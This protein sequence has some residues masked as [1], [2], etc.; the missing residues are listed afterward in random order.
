MADTIKFAGSKALGDDYDTTAE[1][2]NDLPSDITATSGHW[3][4]KFKKGFN[5]DGFTIPAFIITDDD[6]QI[7]FEA[8]D[9][10][11]VD[12]TGSGAGFESAIGNAGGLIETQTAQQN[13]THFN[14]IGLKII[15]TAGFTGQ[16]ALDLDDVTNKLIKDCY[17]SNRSVSG[18]GWGFNTPN[19]AVCITT[20]ENCIIADCTGSG[21]NHGNAGGSS[22]ITMNRVTSV[23]NGDDG[24]DD[25]GFGPAS[26]IESYRNLLSFGN[27]DND[28]NS[29]LSDSNVNYFAGGDG[30]QSEAPINFTATSA[31]FVD[32]ANGD[33]SLASNSSLKGAGEN[34]EDIGATLPANAGPP[35]LPTIV[36]DVKDVELESQSVLISIVSSLNGST[37]Q[38]QLNVTS[39]N[40]LRDAF[41]KN[42]QSQN[43][44][45]IS[46]LLVVTSAELADIY[47]QKNKAQVE[48]VNNFVKNDYHISNIVSSN[49]IVNNVTLNNKQVQ[50]ESSFV[51]TF[52][53]SDYYEKEFQ[54][55][56]AQI[57]LTSVVRSELKDIQLQNSNAQG[58]IVITTQASLSD[59]NFQKENYL[60]NVIVNNSTKESQFNFSYG[61]SFLEITS[62]ALL[63]DISLQNDNA[64]LSN[65]INSNLNDN[66]FH[67]ENIKLN[68]LINSTLQDISS[69]QIKSLVFY[70][71]V[72]GIG[73]G[74]VNISVLGQSVISIDSVTDFNLNIK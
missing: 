72:E 30:T 69:Q 73:V 16:S 36:C 3:R 58:N 20:F 40:S 35:P 62:D 14:I 50:L 18:S 34:G 52:I 38:S 55:S 46:K 57:F 11:E 39:L 54:D 26:F 5:F 15:A 67:I 59:I 4:V 68:S 17:I 65:N 70:N 19:A 66:T 27:T 31:D 45:A 47:Y 1:I 63:M 22:R 13:D 2:L 33:Y 21:T 37:L 12:G 49:A 71:L 29:R 32:Y 74:K 61:E 8:A 44:K 28:F 6:H 25:R 64:R 48:V 24:F 56:N 42:T 41:F 53:D 23:N 60:L 9:G 7:Y 51:N 43:Q 10:D